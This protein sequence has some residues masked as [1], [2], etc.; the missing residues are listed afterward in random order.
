MK[1]YFF[2]ILL[3]I[4]CLITD[5]SCAKTKRKKKKKKKK[6]TRAA[7]TDKFDI[8]LKKKAKTCHR[9]TRKG[10]TV[11]IHFL[12][13]VKKSGVVFDNS[14][15]N[16]TPMKITL[17]RNEVMEGWDRGLL[18]M[19]VGEMRKLYI[20]WNLGYKG[21]PYPQIKPQDTLHFEIELLAIYSTQNEL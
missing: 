5:V 21:I 17:G 9:K 14:F 16:N 12:G 15:V 10:D 4:I 19:C 11:K 1:I 3:V 2:I 20:P 8:V 18:D 13:K 7:P 6:V